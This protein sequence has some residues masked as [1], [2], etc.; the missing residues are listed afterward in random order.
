MP[1]EDGG[2][3]SPKLKVYGTANIRVADAS[4]LP[5]VSLLSAIPR[6]SVTYT[7]FQ[8]L[9]THLAGTVYSI[10]EQAADMIKADWGH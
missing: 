4:I 3:V 2:V 5:M 1:K 10:A 7:S 9:G 8:E 6:P